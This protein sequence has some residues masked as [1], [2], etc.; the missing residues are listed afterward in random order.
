MKILIFG[1][2]GATGQHLVKQ[3]LEQ[4][5]HVTAFVRNMG[6]LTL[7]HENLILAQGNIIHDETVNRAVQGQDAVFSALGAQSPFKFDQAI[8]DGVQNIIDAMNRHQVKRL[9]YLSTIGGKDNREDFGFFVRHIAPVLLKNEIAG[10]EIR[11]NMIKQS[12]LDYT[13]VQ[14]PKLTNGKYTGKYKSGEFIKSKSFATS[15]SRADTA[16]FM[17]KQL[18]VREYIR[19]TVRILPV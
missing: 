9:I 18:T 6:K 5:H 1:A 8:V 3:A 19:K 16:E 7:R 13:I 17:L 4:Q 15:L 14:A 12:S 2:S 10:H 11:E